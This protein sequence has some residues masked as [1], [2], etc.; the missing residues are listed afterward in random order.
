M[1]AYARQERKY[2]A[3]CQY[4]A[5]PLVSIFPPLKSSFFDELPFLLSL[6]HRMIEQVMGTFYDTYYV[7]RPCLVFLFAIVYHPST[8]LL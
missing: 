1:A 7:V 4:I 3:A 2:S 6:S 5:E 8:R